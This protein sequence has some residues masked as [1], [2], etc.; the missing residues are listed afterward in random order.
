MQAC[1]INLVFISNCYEYYVLLEIDS[2]VDFKVKAA[3]CKH[4][5]QILD[6][7]TDFSYFEYLFLADNYKS[8]LL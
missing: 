6:V 3:V 5:L 7:I 2:R 8:C 4:T 1:L